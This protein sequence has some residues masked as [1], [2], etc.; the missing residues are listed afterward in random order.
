MTPSAGRG[1]TPTLRGQLVTL[2]RLT[3]A[4]AD[5]LV[6]ILAEPEVARWWPMFDRARVLRELV[7]EREAEEGFAIE[8]DGRVVGY[9]QA[10]EEVDPEFRHASIDLFLAGAS[11]GRGL[12]PDAIR[13][14]AADLI[15]R[16]GHHRI[17]IDPAADNAQAIGAYAK[18]GFRQVGRLRQYQLMRDGTWADALLMEMLTGEL[19]RNDPGGT[20]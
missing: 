19:V 15:D 20:S 14:L 13:A 2:R 18:V 5:A 8:L 17:T 11:Q 7:A 4:D 12:G 1:G 10:A 9:I 3:A 6:A 16:R